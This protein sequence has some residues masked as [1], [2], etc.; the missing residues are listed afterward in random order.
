MSEE[1]LPVNDFFTIMVLSYN[2]KEFLAQCLN[3]I[4]KTDYDKYKV[5][6]YD[7]A[8]T[9]GT[10][11]MLRGIKDEQIQIIYGE[12]NIG[13]NAYYFM[14]EYCEGNVVTVDDD[15]L[16]IPRDWLRLFYLAIVGIPNL[17]YLSAD[18]VQDDY[19]N[20]AKPPD[21]NYT[22][23][24]YGILNVQEGMWTGGWCS[25]IPE[26]V[27]KQCGPYV[28]KPHLTWVPTDGFYCSKVRKHGYKVGILNNIKVYHASGPK[29]NEMY[30]SLWEE[31][32]DYA[33]Q[34]GY[35]K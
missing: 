8:S 25:V 24:Q 18:V 16:E 28:Y 12:K 17:G 2:R 23:Q 4:Y 21:E 27:Y 5:I 7:N 13:Q 6:V 32:M 20:G 35:V 10:K 11:E 33:K 15:V 3:E 26:A 14:H 31:K 30:G 22:Q 34:G 9:D 29:C 1:F 19:T